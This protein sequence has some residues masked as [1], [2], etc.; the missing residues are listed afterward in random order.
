MKILIKRI[1]SSDFSSSRM[2]LAENVEINLCICTQYFFMVHDLKGER[3]CVSK[4]IA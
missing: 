4:K 3:D 1:F 2:L